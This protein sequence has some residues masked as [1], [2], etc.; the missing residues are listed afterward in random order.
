MT[1][2]E[3]LLFRAAIANK[4]VWWRSVDGEVFRVVGVCMNYKTPDDDVPEPVAVLENNTHASLIN[5]ETSD[6]FEIRPLII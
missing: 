6:Y 2:K 3:I 4:E 1:D 5:S